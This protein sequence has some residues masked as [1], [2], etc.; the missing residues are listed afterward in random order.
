MAE[1]TVRRSAAWLPVLGLGFAL[2]APAQREAAQAPRPLGNKEAADLLLSIVKPD[3]PAVARVNYI[4]GPVQMALVVGEDGRVRRV[5]VLHGNPLLAASALS[6]VRAWLYKPFLTAA[7]PQPFS[8]QVKVS[9]SLREKDLEH[10]PSAPERDLAAAVKPPEVV[11]RPS[12]AAAAEAIRL[13]VLVGED[14]RAIDTTLL[15]GP[16]AMLPSAEISVS[17]W[18]FRPARWGNLTVPWYLDVDVPVEG[19][20]QLKAW[21]PLLKP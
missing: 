21:S 4:E 5:H 1:L 18:Q 8:T 20:G 19:S 10:S 3:Y 13:Q 7:G 11:G 6:A 12:G 16:P 17:Q 15:S 2:A 9:F 14:G